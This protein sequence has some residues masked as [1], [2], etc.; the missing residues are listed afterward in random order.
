LAAAG[1]YFSTYI[2]SLFFHKSNINYVNRKIKKR[3]C[4]N[5]I[6]TTSLL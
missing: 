4:M 2:Y 3:N 1:K 5:D 6:H